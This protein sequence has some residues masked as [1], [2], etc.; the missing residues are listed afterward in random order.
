ME[1]KI[2]QLINEFKS[3]DFTAKIGDDIE[4]TE[5]WEIIIEKI[6][7]L[8][9]FLK[10]AEEVADNKLMETV[11]QNPDK[12]AYEGERIKLLYYPRTTYKVE[13]TVEDKYATL[14]KVPNKKTI[15]AFQ[16]VYN[17]LPK[18]VIKEVNYSITKKLV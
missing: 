14:K 5:E 12:V 16:K 3:I 4:V 2:N 15:E 11:K 7:L 9:K 17:E 13:D 8:K 1:E 6:I 18:G 10:E